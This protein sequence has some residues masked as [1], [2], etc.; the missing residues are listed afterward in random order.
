MTHQEILEK[1]D[2]KILKS[3]ISDLIYIIPYCFWILCLLEFTGITIFLSSLMLIVIW[4]IK[5][6]ESID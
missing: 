3:G 6:L 5:E 4:V 2:M 1:E